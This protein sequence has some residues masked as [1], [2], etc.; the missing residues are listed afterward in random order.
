N[1]TA[2]KEVATNITAVPTATQRV[3]RGTKRPVRTRKKKITRDGKPSTSSL[4]RV[5]GNCQT[6]WTAASTA[7]MLGQAAPKATSEKEANQ[8]IQS[9]DLR[10]KMSA[11]TAKYTRANKRLSDNM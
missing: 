1:G 3:Q 6:G 10:Q 8:A 4:T 9:S 11:A 2:K 7:G 5:T